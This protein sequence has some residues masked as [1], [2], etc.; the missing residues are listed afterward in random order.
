MCCFTRPVKSVSDTKIF[1]RMSAKGRQF[2]VY[3]MQV[4]A[5]EPLAMVLPIPVAEGTK[6]S[7]VQFL[8]LSKYPQFFADME[9]GFPAYPPMGAVTASSDV[10]RASAAPLKVQQVGSYEA[11]FVPTVKDFSR[12][13]ERFRLPTK[14]FAKLKGYAKFGFAVFKLKKGLQKVHPMAFEFPSSSPAR[15]FFPTVHIHDGEVH[16]KARFDH[17][18]YCQPGA[19]HRLKL[20]EWRE[21]SGLAG[22]FMKMNLAK[23]LVL[24]GEH[25]YKRVLRGNLANTDTFVEPQV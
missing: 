23:D 15:L 6:E 24:A 20:L 2:V 18:L 22:Q 17:D 12:L 21:S 16:A 1:A 11:S 4:S 7:A 10:M 19:D 5:A 25:C 9:T 3:S 13:D 14:S 8:N